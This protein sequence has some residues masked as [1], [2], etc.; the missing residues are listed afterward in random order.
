MHW[1]VRTDRAAK[2]GALALETVRAA[3]LRDGRMYAFVAGEQKL[4][5]GIRRHWSTTVKL[6]KHDVTFTGYWR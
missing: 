3:Q 1:L 2:P 6:P 5:S 4:A